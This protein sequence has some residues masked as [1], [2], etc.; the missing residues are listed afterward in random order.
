MKVLDLTRVLAGPYCCA[1][2]ADLG[3]DVIRVE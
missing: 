2:L 1:I 3:A